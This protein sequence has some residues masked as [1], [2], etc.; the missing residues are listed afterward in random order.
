MRLS[1]SPLAQLTKTFPSPKDQAGSILAQM[2]TPDLQSRIVLRD[3]R[4]EVPADS[5]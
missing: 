4:G 2:S 5:K 1:T 3:T